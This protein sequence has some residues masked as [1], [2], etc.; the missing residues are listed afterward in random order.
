M[1]EDF[2]YSHQGR[3][4]RQQ[5]SGW[6]RFQC[7]GSPSHD[8]GSARQL[9]VTGWGLAFCGHGAAALPRP[10][11][12]EPC[13]RGAAM[14]PLATIP[15]SRV[16]RTSRGD[17]ACRS[18]PPAPRTGHPVAAQRSHARA[19]LRPV[20]RDGASAT[21]ASDL[22]RQDLGTCRGDGGEVEAAPPVP[23]Y[24]VRVPSGC[25]E[26]TTRCYEMRCLRRADA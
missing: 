3:L 20:A 4:R 2:L 14:R 6:V 26:S 21:L 10:F 22:P 24:Y 15:P 5:G 17:H 23:A 16:A 9:A 13:G 25:P 19:G 8:A 1:R 11:G 12:R 7:A 18:G